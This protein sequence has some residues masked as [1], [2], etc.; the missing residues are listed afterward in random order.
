MNKP[1]LFLRMAS[2]LTLIHAVLHTMGGVFGAIPPGP[3]SVAVLAM[4][5]NAFVALGETRTFWEYYRGMGLG[6]SIFLT[7][8]AVVF[9]LLAS[10][11]KRNAA[12]LRPV[13]AAFAIAYVVFAM[14]S[15]FYFFLAPVVTEL[16]IAV[17]LVLAIATAKAPDALPTTAAS[18][19]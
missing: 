19:A 2:V 14:D 6:V 10:I 9:W 15:Y 3:A 4:K 18:G 16:L 1:V 17:C 13:L 8:E 5:T 7:A 11:A 12:T